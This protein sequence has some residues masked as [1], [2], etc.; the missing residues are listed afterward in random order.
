[1]KIIRD[2][3]R[4]FFDHGWLKTYHTFSFADYYDEDKMNFGLLRVF[5]D[6]VVD[7]HRGFDMHSHQNM[8]IITIPLFGALEHEDSTGQKGI[9]RPGDIQVMSAGRGIIHS[10]KIP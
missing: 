2:E 6:D 7:G 1:M 4:G 10:E 9:I 3:Q 8:E 5:N